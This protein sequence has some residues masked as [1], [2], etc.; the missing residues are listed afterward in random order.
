LMFG[1]ALAGFFAR[2][3][4][5]GVFEP[6]SRLLML[7]D[8]SAIKPSAKPISEPK[9]SEPKPSLGEVQ[10][11]EPPVAEIVLPELE[12]SDFVVRKALSEAAPELAPWL[13]S[14]GLIRKFM[15][16]A[17]DLS[18]GLR[19]NKHFSFLKP[20]QAFAV[21]QEKSGIFIADRSYQ[22]YNALAQAIDHSN[23]DAM[24]STYKTF[25]PLFLQVFSEFS[26]PEEYSL[27]ML[28]NKAITEILS[29]PI[30]EGEIPLI[31]APLRYQ[32]ADPQLEALNPVHKQMLRMGP[33]NTRLIQN[34]LRLLLE[35]LETD[36]PENF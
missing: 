29:A 34:K 10:T 30:I 11:L 35:Q 21:K 2:P 18:Q 17:N 36:K 25:K 28:F 13:A 19:I 31:K 5:D 3:V 1:A 15:A 16:I 7:V 20:P 27:D 23:S 26:Y 8:G 12:S 4:F 6:I 9:L 32:Y 24:I 33:E 14:N 22:R